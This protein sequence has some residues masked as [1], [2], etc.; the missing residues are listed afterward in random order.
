MRHLRKGA[1]TM[2]GPTEDYG[3][4]REPDDA[5]ATSEAQVL[6]RT[7]EVTT[8]TTQAEPGSPE[9]GARRDADGRPIA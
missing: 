1:T 2:V 4:V 8:D 5:E 3:T 6:G 9:T 7:V